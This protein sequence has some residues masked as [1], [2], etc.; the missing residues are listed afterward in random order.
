MPP[1]GMNDTPVY[2]AAIALRNA[3]PPM[4]SAG[5]NF[6]TESPL[7]NAIS[8]SVGVQTPGNT[9]RSTLWQ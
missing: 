2:G 5:K 7:P 6:T 1:V 3:R 9:G 8:T 4:G